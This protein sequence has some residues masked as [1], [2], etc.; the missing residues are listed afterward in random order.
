[1][2]SC[3]ADIDQIQLR[4][5]VLT[6]TD[7]LCHRR[8]R[9]R[10]HRRNKWSSMS[11]GARLHFV[12]VPGPGPTASTGSLKTSK[13]HAAREAHAKKRRQ[14]MKEYQDRGGEPER[15]QPAAASDVTLARREDGIGK[16]DGRVPGWDIGT[17][18]LLDHLSSSYTDPFS[19]LGRHMTGMEYFLLHHCECGS[20]TRRDPRPPLHRIGSN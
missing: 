11:T 16:D 10:Y 20:Q 15:S 2:T 17:S 14:R 4:T 18:Q 9:N 13:S 19:S 7:T 5:E 8:Q 3:S 12:K 6:R 1:M